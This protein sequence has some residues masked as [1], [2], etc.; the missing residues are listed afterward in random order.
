MKPQPQSLEAENPTAGNTENS[1]IGLH[2][3]KPNNVLTGGENPL[4]Y[5]HCKATPGAAVDVEYQTP[6]MGLTDN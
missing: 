3:Q 6:L 5:Y 4:Q 1:T 2:V